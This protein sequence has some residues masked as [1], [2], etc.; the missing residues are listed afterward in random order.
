MKWAQ[1]RYVNAHTEE[2]AQ[3][4]IW[5]LEWFPEK[6]TQMTVCEHTAAIACKWTFSTTSFKANVAK[7]RKCLKMILENCAILTEHNNPQSYTLCM[8]LSYSFIYGNCSNVNSFPLALVLH[9]LMKLMLKV[10]FFSKFS[11]K[12]LFTQ[13][14][15]IILPQKCLSRLKNWK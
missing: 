14:W 6:F 2:N 11:S 8:L 7:R 9:Y 13:N 5:T 12:L 1:T 15:L 3:N 4:T 10:Y